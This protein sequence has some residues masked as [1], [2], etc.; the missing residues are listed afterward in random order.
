MK[1][2]IALVYLAAGI[3]S[4]FGGGIKQLAK[5][6]ANGESL[7][8]CS[9]EQA[10]SAGF[11]KIVLIVGN[12]TEMLIK[13][14]LGNSYKGIPIYYALQTFDIAKREKPWGTA[15]AI[16]C[17]AQYLNCSFIVC[18]GDDLYG[19]KNFNK[20]VKHLRERKENAIIGFKLKG[21]LPEIG[22]VNRAVISIKNSFVNE[23]K[24]IFGIEK[25]NLKELGLN[26]EE[27]CS[28]NFFGF[29]SNVIELLKSSVDEFKILH[30]N[31]RNAEC[32][33]PEEIN[34][35]IKNKIIN[36]VCY[37]SEEKSIGI[38]NPEDEVVVK[39]ILAKAN[40]LKLLKVI[41]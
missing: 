38:T 36:M 17:A 24:E 23:I 22:K 3:S 27:L 15:D 13:E 20:L 41:Q 4:R 35:L 1:E 28:M 8:E 19:K 32:L 34:K 6:G 25:N 29:Q 9:L 26:G 39:N 40:D 7:I 37:T 5:V 30:K 21:V 33:L 11:S 10:F 31:D 12:K 18:N 14:K 2:E 16:C